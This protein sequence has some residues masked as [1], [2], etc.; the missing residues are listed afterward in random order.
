MKANSIQVSNEK[1]KKVKIT[2]TTYLLLLKIAQYQFEV[3]ECCWQHYC[4]DITHH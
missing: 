2:P 3:L 4:V 1:E